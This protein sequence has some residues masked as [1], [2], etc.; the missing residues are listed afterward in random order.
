[1]RIIFMGSPQEVIAP[2]ETLLEICAGSDHE[3]AA[4]VSQPAKP[5]GR[6]KKLT[7]PPV[8]AYA[9]EHQLPV[10]QPEK[11]RSP[12]FLQ[13]LKELAPDLIITAAYGQILSEAFLA[14]PQRGTI[15]IHPSLL[16]QYRGATPVQTALYDGQQ[17]TGVT[18]LFTV[19]ALDAGNIIEQQEL[20]ID[21]H[22][23]SFEIMPRLFK[24]GGK[25]LIKA[26]EKLSDPNF[27]GKSQD[28]KQVT[29]C[30]KFTKDSGQINWSLST[31]S[32]YNRYR[33]FQPWPG[34]FCFFEGKR[35][36]LEAI[37]PSTEG[38]A[39]LDC[40]E[41]RYVKALQSVIVKTRD[42]YLKLSR[43]K[44]EGSKSIEGVAFWNG[45]KLKNKGVF[46]A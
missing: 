19:K 12:E 41:F 1:M 25:M 16:P 24:L 42:G 6:K 4:I 35:I 34:V 8:A 21:P 33:A 9:K 30:H 37:S 18:I 36:V 5:A 10:L 45:L 32:I 11:S 20:T 40:R 26:L 22:E 3:L 46:D 14:I 39:D 28:A 7:D 38:P 44:P 15:N 43:V 29:E 31:Q 13:T 27:S 23:T 17:R 2:L